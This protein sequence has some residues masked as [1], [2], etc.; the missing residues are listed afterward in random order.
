MQSLLVSSGRDATQLIPGARVLLSE[1]Y[2]AVIH[3]Y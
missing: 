2:S 1:A 3:A